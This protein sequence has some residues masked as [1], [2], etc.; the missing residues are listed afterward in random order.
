MTHERTDLTFPSLAGDLARLARDL[1]RE[2]GPQ[3]VVDTVVAQAVRMV[4]GAQHASI[5]LVRGRRHVTSAAA[6]D[7][8]A[9][10]F[11]ELQEELGEGPCL[12]ALHVE[13]VVSVAD[14]A[15]ETRWPRLAGEGPRR[16]GVRSMLCFQLFVAGEVMGNLNLLADAPDTFDQEA[17]QAGEALVAHAALALA[18]SRQIE[19]L[20]NALVNRDRIGQA[21]GILVE[22]FKITPDQAFSLLS[23]ISQD[24]NQKLH[25]VA[26]QLVREGSLERRG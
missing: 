18:A 1:Q 9:E 7:T 13:P 8:V 23:R 15:A 14:L 4:D 12:D 2:S 22:R 19:N 26:A 5:G 21:K 3:E 24:R 16:L 10:R 25:E 20:S 17:R 6:T 11:D